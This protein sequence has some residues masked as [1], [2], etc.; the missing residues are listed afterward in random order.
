MKKKATGQDTAS[1]AERH[2]M[3]Y[4]MRQQNDMMQQQGDML[5]D[6]R[7][8]LRRIVAEDANITRKPRRSK[9]QLRQLSIALEAL[10]RDPLRNVK[11]AAEYAFK[12]ATGYTTA[13]SLENV[14][15][16]KWNSR[17]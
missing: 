3:L 14:L 13:H 1:S 8:L 12:N 16:R 15:R 5:A 7:N 6:M 17:K 4:L 9:D 10:E 11:K 2:E